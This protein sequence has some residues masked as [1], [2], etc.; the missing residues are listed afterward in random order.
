MATKAKEDKETLKAKQKAAAAAEIEVEKQRHA[1]RKAAMYE[2]TTGAAVKNILN[3]FLPFAKF[4]RN[5]VEL[6]LF[7]TSPELPSFTTDLSTWIFNL[8]KENMQKLY[9]GTPGFEWKDSKKRAEMVD[10]DT[11]YLIARRKADQQPVAFVSFR[12]M[13]EGPF[14]VLYIWELQL[15]KEVQRKGLGK[16]M[17]TVCELAARKTGMQLYVPLRLLL[18]PTHPP[19]APRT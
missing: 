18:P 14:D 9:D 3:E 11:R 15:T 4:D 13:L 17:M 10:T 8:T 16:H 12:F 2:D 7:F 5:G 19:H 6:E 1:K